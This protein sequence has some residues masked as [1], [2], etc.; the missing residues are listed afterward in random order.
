MIRGAWWPLLALGAAG[1]LGARWFEHR[2]LFAPSRTLDRSPAEAGLAFEE[3]DFVAEDG[4][5]LHGWWIPHPAA[6]G[7]LLYCHGNGANI[8]NRVGVLP[9]LH[10]Q[11]LNVFLF[12]YRGYGFS[13]GWPS[14]RGLARDAR[15]AYEVVRA[16][17]DDAEAPPVVLYGASLGGPVAARL[18]EEKPARGIIVEAS[19]PSAVTL[20]AILYPALPIRWMTTQRFDAAGPL[21]RLAGLPKLIA[22][23][24][25]D[26]LVPFDLGEQLFDAA[27][28]PKQFAAFLGPHG[29]GAWDEHLSY[30]AALSS[31]F[32]RL[33][34]P[35]I[36]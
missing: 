2:A 25:E 7:T 29:E 30:A 1:W 31:F 15:A 35:V 27:A 20:G 36:Q 26:G 32:D 4:V 12:D 16:R 24:R 6:R 33:F 17:H 8:A 28:E 9:W 3:V 5:R 14:E 13:R 21:S 18:A 22:N 23:S 11:Q 10:A 19:F 34:G